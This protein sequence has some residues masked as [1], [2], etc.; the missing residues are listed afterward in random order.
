[1][2]VVAEVIKSRQILITTMMGIFRADGIRK[3]TEAARRF[4]EVTVIAPIRREVP[5]L[6]HCVF[7]CPL[8]LKEINFEWTMCRPRWTELPL[9]V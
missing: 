8:I 6:H 9:T 1:M 5:L 3:L 4:G 7:N 2:Y